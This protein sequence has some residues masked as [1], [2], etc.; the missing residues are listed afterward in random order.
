MSLFHNIRELF[1]LNK[2]ITRGFY[3]GGSR[4]NS[5]DFYNANAPFESTASTDRSTLTSRARWLHENNGIMANID[6]AIVDNSLGAEGMKLKVKSSNKKLNK[7]IE[8]K[9]EEWCKKEFCD[10]TGRVSFGSMQRMVLSQRMMDGEIFA[11]KK[12]TN[13]RKHPFTLQLLE[14]DRMS[15][16]M[17]S[18]H[19]ITDANF[20]DGISVDKNGKP[21]LYHFS[22]ISGKTIDV[23]AEHMIHYYKST[24]RITQYR[25]ITEYRQAIIDLRNFAGY[26]TAV[27]KSARARSNVAYAV[28]TPDAGGHQK[29]HS[30]GHETKAKDPL[31]DI[32]GVVVEYLNPGE[33]IHTLDPSA[34]GMDYPDFVTASVRLIAV[35]RQISYELAFRDYSQVNF[36]SAR[37]SI[38]QDNKRFDAEQIH[39]VT[40][41]LKPVFSE[42]LEANILAGN[43]PGLSAARY[44]QDEDEFKS[45]WIPP[46]RDWVDPLKDI[47]AFEKDLELNAATLTE[48]LGS[49][50][51][52]IDDVLEERKEEIQKLRDAGILQEEEGKKNEAEENTRFRT[53]FGRS[54]RS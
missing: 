21:T 36:A 35:A 13:D 9:W 54:N 32:N 18:L 50:G 53:P 23:K 42:W 34:V 33:K 4:A 14:T 38:I 2:Q 29:G 47:R 27:I 48:Y 40:Y 1:G 46:K 43:I 17:N 19:S 15:A 26:Q 49:K 16:S 8:K 25:G 12:Y 20:V 37:A 39:M 44:Y 22:T 51:K 6:S 7:I 41:F 45:Y 30:F 10:I 28:E 3:E 24:N 52:D 5:R 31:Y 11:I